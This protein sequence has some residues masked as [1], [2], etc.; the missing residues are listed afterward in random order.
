MNKISRTKWLILLSLRHLSSVSGLEVEYELL[1]FDFTLNLFYA[2]LFYL[3]FAFRFP[4]TNRLFVYISNLSYHVNYTTCTKMYVY[5]K[6]SLSLCSFG[7]S[8]IF[9]VGAYCHHG[10]YRIFGFWKILKILILMLNSDCL[11]CFN[12]SKQ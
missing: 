1:T 7:R 6:V 2:C 10:L 4:E 5:R 3:Y 9:F 8:L 12:V 11:Q